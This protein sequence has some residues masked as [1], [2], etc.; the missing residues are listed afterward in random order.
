MQ[1]LNLDFSRF[2]NAKRAVFLSMVEE[3]CKNQ[4][5]FFLEI[6][7]EGEFFFEEKLAI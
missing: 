3:K 7:N 5:A 1:V 6:E 2:V 4:S